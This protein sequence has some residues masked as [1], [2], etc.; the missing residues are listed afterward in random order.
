MAYDKNHTGNLFLVLCHV[1]LNYY[2]CLCQ[3]I[4]CHDSLLGV[5]S[6]IYCPNCNLTWF[7]E[8]NMKYNLCSILLNHKGK[9][10]RL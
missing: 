2:L 1:I 3:R 8:I 9:S 5:S 7:S 6:R 4:M 10:N